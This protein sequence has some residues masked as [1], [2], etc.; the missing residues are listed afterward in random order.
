MKMRSFLQNKLWRD[1]LPAKKEKMGSVIHIQQLTDNEFDQQL[2]IKL[3]EESTEVQATSSQ[4]ELIEEM[5][6][7]LEVIDALC[8]LHNITKEDIINA[9]TNKRE[10]RGGFFERKFV[11][12]ADHPV[13]SCGEQYCLAQPKKYPEVKKINSSLL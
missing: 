12:V 6:D 7:V 2:K 9:Q 10:E 4:K 8:A 11:T 3:L 1:K 13:G 5:A